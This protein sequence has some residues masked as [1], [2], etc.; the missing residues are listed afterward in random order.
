M[1]LQCIK[2]DIPMIYIFCIVNCIWKFL[3][4]LSF[5]DTK[6]CTRD[7]RI[8]FLLSYNWTCFKRNLSHCVLSH[9]S[10]VALF[11]TL[12]MVAHQVPLSMGFSGQE[13]WRGSSKPRRSS[14]PRDK[15]CVSCGSFIAGRF[16]TSEPL[17]SS[18]Q[19]YSN[20]K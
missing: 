9:F 3:L 6:E 16:C 1:L 14:R 13:Y 2:I 5:S 19:L 4:F 20:R 15:T 10:R 8:S 11:A 7:S 18:N 12:W 17:G